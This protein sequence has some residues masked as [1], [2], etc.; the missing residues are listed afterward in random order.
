[1]MR[2]RFAAALLFLLFAAFPLAAAT[3]PFRSG[4]ILAA[5]LSTAKPR[6]V[7]EDP[8]AFPV[9]FTRRIYAELVVKAAEGR[10]LSIHD[11]ALE[12]FGRSY[13]CIALRVGDSD[14]NAEVWEVRRA[15]PREKYTLLF[16]LDATLVGLAPNET[17]K[18]RSLYP[19]K[20]RAEQ[21]VP[22]TNLGGRSFT[23]PR[24]IPDSGLMKK[25]GEQ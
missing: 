11:Y 24:S 4:E 19:P 22:F 23:Q 3:L 25:A 2:M 9:E 1:M 18:L 15:V 8:L 5:E 20:S 10:G 6:I 14:F 17:L 7:N 12:A 21:P 16:M 13:P